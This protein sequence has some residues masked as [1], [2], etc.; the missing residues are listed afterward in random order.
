M[1]S[2]HILSNTSFCCCI[3]IYLKQYVFP[4]P[5]ETVSAL[6]IIAFKILLVRKIIFFL[7]GID[8]Y[9]AFSVHLHCLNRNL[10]IPSLCM[11]C[12][13]KAYSVAALINAHLV[14][15]GSCDQVT[16]IRF[17]KH[18]QATQSQTKHMH[19]SS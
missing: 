2:T 12:S 3:E 15:L 18:L 4:V 10:Y 8:V 11:V 6:P 19:A 14:P 7:S 5:R 16:H 13:S 1:Q 9:R 17:L